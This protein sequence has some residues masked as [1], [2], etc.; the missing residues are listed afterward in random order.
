M[1][2]SVIAI[3]LSLALPLLMLSQEKKK[4]VTVKTVEVENGK[5][6]VKDTTFTIQEGE[7]IDAIAEPFVWTSISDSAA[8]MT[9]D[10]EV[11]TGDDGGDTKK[12][13]IIKERGDR[14]MRIVEG[15]DGDVVVIKKRYNGNGDDDVFFTPG[16]G[17][18]RVMKWTDDDSVEYEFEMQRSMEEFEHQMEIQH[19]NMEEMQKQLEAQLAEIKGIDEEQLTQIMDEINDMDFHFVMPP[20]RPAHP[21]QKMDKDN[22]ALYFDGPGNEG[23]VSDM[24]LREANI[25]NK[26]DRLD[27]GEIDIN[28]ENGVLDI[29]FSVEGEAN[30]SIIIYNVYGDKVFSGKP[31]LMNGKFEIKVDL[32]QKQHGTYYW[33]IV[34]KNRSFTDKIRI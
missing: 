2:T 23:G 1:K 32:S 13:I 28:I 14:P 18:K 12:V 5:K 31:V 33:Q 25:K 26:P 24:E 20:V 16:P 3:L 6:I 17:H 4:T 19:R 22:F 10:V 15:N 34:D 29:S 30:P 7:D 27:L 8:T 9:F 11:E 21:P